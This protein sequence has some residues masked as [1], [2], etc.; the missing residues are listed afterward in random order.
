MYYTKNRSTEKSR[1]SDWNFTFRGSFNNK[2]I[3]RVCCPDESIINGL[4][5]CS[6]TILGHWAIW[7]VQNSG[8]IPETFH[9]DAHF[10]LTSGKL[11]VICKC[12]FFF[13]S[14]T[15][16]FF[17]FFLYFKLNRI[18]SSNYIN[19]LIIYIFIYLWKFRYFFFNPFSRCIKFVFARIVL[20]VFFIS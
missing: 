6:K 13:F 10:P 2:M 16:F 8:N 3:W 11:Y 14:L 7:K 17:F 1:A 9:L 12:N 20:F 4:N 5:I 18:Y 15:T 19:L